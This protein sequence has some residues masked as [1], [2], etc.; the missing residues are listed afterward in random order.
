VSLSFE[1]RN[2]RIHKR[3]SSI[4]GIFYILNQGNGPFY[5]LFIILNLKPDNFKKRI[6]S[7]PPPLK[8]EILKEVVKGSD[9]LKKDGLLGY[10]RQAISGLRE[11]PSR[12]CTTGSP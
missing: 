2:V 10:R 7:H 5:P 9:T 11:T 3:R 1:E 12:V 6:K 4:A 8:M